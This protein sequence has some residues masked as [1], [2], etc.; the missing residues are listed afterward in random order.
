MSTPAADRTEV[1]NYFV[2]NYP[3]FSVWTPRGRD[4]GREASARVA[5][6]PDRD[7]SLL[8]FTCTFRSAG[9][10]ATSAIS[11]ST[12]TRTR[13]RCSPTSTCSRAS[14]SCYNEQRAIAGRPL[15]F[16]YFGGGTPSSISTRQ[17]ESLVSRLDA[18]ELV[19]I[20]GRN[21]LRVRAGNPDREQARGDPRDRRHTPEP[22][23]REFRRRDS[24]AERESA[25]IA[26]DRARLRVRAVARVPADQ[27]RSHC[28]HARRDRRELDTPAFRRR[29]TSRPTA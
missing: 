15:N 2:A 28:R 22:R 9:S 1:G 19:A 3:P 13:T 10:A 17:L 21:H 8:G 23:H 6:A 4:S 18:R 7:V 5:S 25:S 26:R 16:V 14:G 20:G 29:S 24:R 12:P 27:H 11:A